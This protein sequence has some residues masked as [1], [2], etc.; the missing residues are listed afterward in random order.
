MQR[1]TFLGR[2]VAGAAT[3]AATPLI[4]AAD[5][6]VMR[7]TRPL[8]PRG[9]LVLFQGD[10]IT[11]GGRWRD[12]DDPNHVFGQSYPYLLAARCGG[13]FPQQQW[14][15]VNRGIS[16]NTV[17]ALMARWEKDALVLKP[18][19]LSILVGANDTLSRFDKG[20]PLPTTV[21]EYA[22]VYDAIIRRTRSALPHVK[23]VLC[24]PFS[25]PGTRNDGHWQAWQKD[26][27]ERRAIVRNLALAHQA[28]FVPLQAMF[29][30]ACKRA[31]AEYWIWDGVHPTSAGHQLIADQWLQVVNRSA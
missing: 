20:I 31:S 10:S 21:A 6:D 3:L 14:R 30:D 27:A 19:V 9:G 13:H 25:L 1:R 12:S 23:L 29:E 2:L 16:G 5:K 8:L 22:S 7:E 17:K 4:K 18:D 28:V 11:D 24:E 15:F 26:M